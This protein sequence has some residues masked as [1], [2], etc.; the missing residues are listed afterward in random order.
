MLNISD[1]NCNYETL[2]ASMLIELDQRCLKSIDAINRAVSWQPYAVGLSSGAIIKSFVITAVSPLIGLPLLGLSG[3][4]MLTSLILTVHHENQ[5]K[6]LKDCKQGLIDAYKRIIP[7]MKPE[8]ME[9]L[10]SALKDSKSELYENIAEL[11]LQKTII[12]ASYIV[13]KRLKDQESELY[14]FKRDKYF[15][16]SERVKNTTEAEYYGFIIDK[17]NHI[18]IRLKKLGQGIDKNIYH[19]FCPQTVKT[20]VQ[21][22]KRK[23]SC[24]L[25]YSEK[26]R[27]EKFQGRGVASGYEFYGQSFTQVNPKARHEMREVFLQKKMEG[28]GH[29]LFDFPVKKQYEAMID[30][31]A[32]LKLIHKEERIHNDIKL[33]NILVDKEGKGYISDFGHACKKGSNYISGTFCYLS[34]EDRLKEE[35]VRP[36]LP[37]HD[38]WSF[39]VMML[40][41][42]SSGTFEDI[43]WNQL[44]EGKTKPYL[45]YLEEKELKDELSRVEK[46]FEEDT[47]LSSEDKKLKLKMLSVIRGLLAHDPKHRITSKEAYELLSS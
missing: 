18:H 41:L 11:K 30:L 23:T 16:D 22:V 32:G 1:S 36:R 2:E 34:P 3:I 47:N 45:N 43:H 6:E 7:T 40:Q 37:S 4:S 26:Y 42:I 24:A 13:E 38:L 28:T 25:L 29:M 31:L 10:T 17:K 12:K 33:S 19:S 9:S 27:Y 21:G 8:N 20:L 14:Y 46:S 5:V 44:V 15:S 35:E 39:G